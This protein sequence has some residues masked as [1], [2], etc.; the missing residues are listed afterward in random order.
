MGPAARTPAQVPARALGGR[1][2]PRAIWESGEPGG[3]GRKVCS[4]RYPAICSQG[5]PGRDGAEGTS[6]AREDRLPQPLPGCAPAR[7]PRRAPNSAEPPQVCGPRPAPS[8]HAYLA[9]GRPP[10]PEGSGAG[11][12]AAAA[13]RPPR[14]RSLSCAAPSSRR[15]ADAAGP[16]GPRRPGRRE[17]LHCRALP[18]A[19]RPPPAARSAARLR[20]D[21]PGGGGGG[22]PPPAQRPPPPRASS[23]SRAPPRPR[24]DTA[25]GP[26]PAP[27]RGR[28][29]DLPGGA[30]QRRRAPRRGPGT[31]TQAAPALEPL[32]SSGTARFERLGRKRSPLLNLLARGVGAGW[33][34][35]E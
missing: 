19:R 24:R 34:G 9:A 3:A 15:R 7:E 23:S 8:S 12:G 11:P 30:P 20:P 22:D 26:G 25:Q 6:G 27:R 33:W 17:P 5:R 2:R 10:R 32:G 31:R 18:A 29:L 21:D 1:P 14:R 4:W 28:G 13:L 16:G 35:R